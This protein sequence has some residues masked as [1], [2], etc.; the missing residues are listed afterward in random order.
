MVNIEDMTTDRKAQAHDSS[1]RREIGQFGQHQRGATLVEALVALALF[2]VAATAIGNLLSQHIR[3]QGT[4][5]TTTSA[6]SLA[7]EE[8]EDLRAL[9]YGDIASRWALKVVG[10][11]SYALQTDVVA[12]SPAANMKSVQTTVTWSEPTGAKRYALYAIYTDVSH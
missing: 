8:L 3:M 10:G 12:D 9:D 5:G 6:I 11:N 4:N 7:E 2:G 1:P